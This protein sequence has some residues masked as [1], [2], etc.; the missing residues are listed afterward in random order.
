MDWSKTKSIFIGIFLILNIFLYSQ[1]LD[2]Y[3][4][5]RKMEVPGEK[6][7]EARLKEDNISYITLPNNVETASYISGKVRNFI[8]AEMPSIPNQ[9]VQIEKGSK[10]LV[11]LDQ[12]VKLKSVDKEALTEFLQMNVYEGASYMLW[13]VDLEK[14]EAMFFQR[15]NDR[16]LYYNENGF[17]KV[18]W[19]AE[20]QVYQY[21][22]TML[23]NLGELDQQENIMPPLQI[24]SILYA[25][26]LLKSDARITSM[27]LGYYTLVQFTQTQVF[28][29]TWE[30]RVRTADDKEEEYFVN[31][32]EGKVIDLQIE[33]IDVE[34]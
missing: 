4:E 17:V 12:P 19:D 18:Y 27:K 28:A 1:Y 31:A 33:T 13:D 23:E 6:N 30:V 8:A 11:T 25:K 3:T 32:V 5:A 7:I 10:L 9:S 29:P 2:R 26:N 16:T 21:E 15:V 14:R 20:G 24:I 22:Q 34:E